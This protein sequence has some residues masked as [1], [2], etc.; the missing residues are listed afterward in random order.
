MGNQSSLLSLVL[1]HEWGALMGRASVAKE[2]AQKNTLY[3]GDNLDVLKQHVKDESVDLVYLDPP[4]NSNADYNVL[5]SDHDVKAAAQIKAFEDTWTWDTEAAKQF[6]ELVSAGGKV[7]DVMEAFRKFLGQSDLMAYLTMMAPR[8]AE[9]RRVMKPTASIYLHCDPTASHYLKVLM[10]AVFGAKNFRNE[11]VWKR[12]TAHSSAKRYAPI[13]DILLYYVRADQASWN[14]PRTDYAAEYLDKYY[15]FDDGDGRLYWRADITGAG[16]VQHGETGQPWRGY[17][18]SSKGRH[19]AYPTSVLERMDRE[20]RIYWPPGG[21]WPQQKRY[22]EDLKGKAVS[23]IWDDIDRINPV[24]G[25]RLGFPTQKPEDLLDRI[26]RASSNEGEVVLDPFCGCG[27]AIA[28]AHRLNRRWIGIDVTHLSVGLIKHRLTGFGAIAGKD[29]QVIGEPTTIQDARK[30]AEE[31]KY[32]FQ[33][34]SLGLVGARPV[35]EKK[36]SDKGIDG[37]RRFFARPGQ[38]EKPL[39]VIFSVKGGQTVPANA[40]RDLLGVIEREK[41]AFGVLITLAEPTQP[42]KSDAAGMGMVNVEGYEG[43]NRYP[44][45]Q[46]VTVG[47]L[48]AGKT[49][50]LPPFATSGGDTT[51]KAAPARAQVKKAPG[52]QANLR[53]GPQ[54]IEDHAKKPREE[55]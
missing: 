4:F 17:A 36:G 47:E 25:E 13:H 22:R 23:D 50:D 39:E 38:G 51:L 45:I 42:M 41:A 31:D 34:W 33:F 5:F 48:L 35:D 12:T 26:V 2:G 16:V 24:G 19:W 40:H 18:V 11:V 43:T 54:T 55:E 14:S 15:R 28:S 1:F 20:G 29:Y 44:R 46:V 21:K 49:L 9:L 37:R 53:G 7:A 30:L 52:R 3:Y 10:D 32:Q 6:E 8:L 27:T